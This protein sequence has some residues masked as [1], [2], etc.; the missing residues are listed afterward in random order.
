L[1]GRRSEEEVLPVVT[2][3]VDDDRCEEEYR[4]QHLQDPG[5]AERLPKVRPATHSGS[6]D[7]FFSSTKSKKVFSLKKVPKCTFKTVS[8]SMMMIQTV[9]QNGR[10]I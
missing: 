8:V 9:I 10:T 6:M 4:L 5:H 1:H 2:V 3:S 7:H